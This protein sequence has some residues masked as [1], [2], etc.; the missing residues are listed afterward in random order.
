MVL[1]EGSS[2]GGARYDRRDRPEEGGTE[3]NVSSWKETGSAKEREDTDLIIDCSV[4]RGES[5]EVRLDSAM[6]GI[7]HG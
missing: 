6:K 7:T 1:G 2:V 5:A 3:R 4:W